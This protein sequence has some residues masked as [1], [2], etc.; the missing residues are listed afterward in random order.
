M[1]LCMGGGSL[2]FES[3]TWSPIS[4]VTGRATIPFSKAHDK[5]PAI[6]AI[7]M[8][9]DG[10]YTSVASA[11]SFFAIDFTTF[12]EKAIYNYQNDNGVCVSVE[13]STSGNIS[14]SRKSLKY[15]GSDTGYE[16]YSIAFRHYADESAMYPCPDNTSSIKWKSDKTYKWIAIWI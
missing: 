7:S 1:Q 15:T 5:P 11:I 10:S 12:R 8:D 6:V 2:K 14:V 13:Y 16:S 3:G 4:D 9:G